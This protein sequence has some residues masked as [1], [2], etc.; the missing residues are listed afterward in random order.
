MLRIL[1]RSE[2]IW[3][4]IVVQSIFLYIDDLFSFRKL[5]RP[6]K[7]LN[8]GIV[9]RNFKIFYVEWFS[10]PS[11]T[12]TENCVLYSGEY[13]TISSSRNILS[14]WNHLMQPTFIPD[15]IYRTNR[16]LIETKMVPY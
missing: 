8:V 10:E 4:S 1:L 6:D 2:R 5:V 3:T 12:N 7:I 9:Q 16:E 11:A 14:S 13:K 15:N